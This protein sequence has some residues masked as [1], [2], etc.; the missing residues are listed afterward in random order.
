M[1]QL[2][3]GNYAREEKDTLAFALSVAKDA[4]CGGIYNLYNT[5]KE[6]PNYRICAD[7][8]LALDFIAKSTIKH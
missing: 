4:L 8:Q 5:C 3:L 1:V 2:K 6:C 7:L